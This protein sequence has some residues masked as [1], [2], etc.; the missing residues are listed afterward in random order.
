MGRTPRTAVKGVAAAISR[1]RPFGLPARGRPALGPV[2]SIYPIVRAVKHPHEEKLQ[3]CSCPSSLP[4][5]GPSSWHA[6]NAERLGGPGGPASTPHPP[7]FPVQPR[8]PHLRSARVSNPAEPATVGLT[9]LPRAV[10][11]LLPA[12]PTSCAGGA[13]APQH[14]PQWSVSCE[15]PKTREGGFVTVV[16]AMVYEKPAILF[17]RPTS[18]VRPS[19]P[20]GKS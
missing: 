3:E 13:R 17:A 9:Y 6:S 2:P 4:P 15:K 19:S 7:Q 5:A 10:A 11:R 1:G 18:E 20:F 14:S 8:R 16:A 12:P